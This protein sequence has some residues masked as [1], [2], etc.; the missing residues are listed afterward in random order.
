MVNRSQPV[1]AV[2]AIYS[3]VPMITLICVALIVRVADV[4]G[5]PWLQYPTPASDAFPHDHRH[6]AHREFK[7]FHFE[8]A[9]AFKRRLADQVSPSSGQRLS[10]ATLHA[11]LA[12]LRR[13]FQ[14]VAG[15]P[16]YKS[17]L[18]YSDAD[19][20]NL[21]DKDSR[22]AT[23]RRERP[24]PTLQQVLHVIAAM[25][26]A[27]V[28]EQRDR[29]LVLVAFTLLTGARDSA[30]ASMKLKHIDLVEG[31]VFQ[32]AREVNTKYSKSFTTYFFPVGEEVRQIVPACVQ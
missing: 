25:P 27:S 26:W 24:F 19:Y 14:W 17:R 15:Q 16:G 10:K 28:V 30:I 23:A 11:T 8:Q 2:G 31:K 4:D 9:I 7:T 29:A 5:S 1:R 32:D 3:G 21:S 18:N 22:V 6:P 13:F 12:H 20:F